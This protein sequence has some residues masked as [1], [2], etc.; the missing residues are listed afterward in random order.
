MEDQK[1]ERHAETRDGDTLQR[2]TPYSPHLLTKLYI[3]KGPQPSYRVLPAE[4]RSF[5]YKP[6]EAI[7]IQAILPSRSSVTTS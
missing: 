2:S 6:A 4:D 7:Q 5:K 3:L 1:A